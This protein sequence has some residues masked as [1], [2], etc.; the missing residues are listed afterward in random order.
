M[1]HEEKALESIREIGERLSQE[2][3]LRYL[4]GLQDRLELEIGA[5]D[6]ACA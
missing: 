5:A 6:E 3:Y 1:N 2:E 4:E